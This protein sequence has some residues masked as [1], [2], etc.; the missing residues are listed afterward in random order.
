L[1][2]SIVANEQ[3]TGKAQMSHSEIIGASRDNSG[4]RYRF[5]CRHLVGLAVTCQP[6]DAHGKPAGQGQ[7]FI[8]PGWILS[9]RDAWCL[10]T[11]GHILK[12][13]DELLEKKK[14]ELDS[15]ALIDSLGPDAVSSLHI[16]FDY[17]ERP[18]FYIYDEQ[19]GLDFGLIPLSSYYR[20]LLEGNRI[21]PVTERDWQHQD[22]VEFSH[23]MMLGFPEEYTSREFVHTESGDSIAISLSPT[24]IW[25]TKLDNPPNDLPE[26]KYPRFVGKLSD[27]LPLDSIVGMSGSPIFGVGKEGDRYWI[28]AVQSSWLR[29]RKITFGCPVSVFAKPIEDMLVDAA[30]G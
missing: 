21:L 10:V 8:Y 11:A 30:S 23:Y 5:L 1:A 6:I 27:E 22:K 28:V 7:L 14:I 26:T 17:Q 16:P 3:P 13:L 24:V 2:A 25:L 12:Q 9:I 29:E 20:N 19:A 4:E 18:K 15:C